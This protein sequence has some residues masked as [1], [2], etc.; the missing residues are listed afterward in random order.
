VVAG[1][2]GRQIP[3]GLM[4]TRTLDLAVFTA[5]YIER[6]KSLMFS[7][8]QSPGSV[9]FAAVA[10]PTGIVRNVALPDLSG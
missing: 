7:R 2:P 10:V 9:A 4:P 3:N 6:T 8:R 5:R 1:T